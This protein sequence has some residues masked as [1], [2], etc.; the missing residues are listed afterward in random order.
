MITKNIWLIQLRED[1][2]TAKLGQNFKIKIRFSFWI[3][4]GIGIIYYDQVELAHVNWVATKDQSIHTGCHGEM[5]RND[6]YICLRLI[7]AGTYS[8]STSC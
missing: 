1:R 2:N 8:A 6:S 7:Y 3:V 5:W 4:V